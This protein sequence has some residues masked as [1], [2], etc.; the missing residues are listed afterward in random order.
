MLPIVHSSRLYARIGILARFRAERHLPA[1]LQ[2]GE[3][4][5][6]EMS[7]RLDIGR[8]NAVWSRCHSL[9]T[10]GKEAGRR[11]PWS[12]KRDA[13][14]SCRRPATPKT[15]RLNTAVFEVGLPI[16][17]MGA[18]L[19]CMRRLNYS[20]EDDVHDRR[21][22]R[23]GLENERTTFHETTSYHR[24]D[25]CNWRKDNWFGGLRSRSSL[26]QSVTDD[27]LIDTDRHKLNAE[28]GAGA[29]Q[30]DAAGWPT[31]GRRSDDVVRGGLAFYTW[32][33]AKRPS[34]SRIVTGRIR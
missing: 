19:Q 21:G 4:G 12:G 7:M 6:N 10:G 16:G 27:R 26:K 11:M 13:R 29:R 2:P 14:L 24:S 9:A 23:T 17:Q 18:F 3:H 33:S 20:S 8:A 1:D 32:N 22:V 28:I 15:Q 30:S 25:V 31:N 34:F 5:G